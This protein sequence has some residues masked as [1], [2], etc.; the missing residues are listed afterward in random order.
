MEIFVGIVIG[1]LIV[2]GVVGFYLI[3]HKDDITSSDSKSNFHES[4]LGVGG[5][6]D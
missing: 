6:G 5:D 2:G 1:L 3:K 4:G